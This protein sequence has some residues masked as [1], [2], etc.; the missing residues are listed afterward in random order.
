M[1]V[2]VAAVNLGYVSIPDFLRAT[3]SVPKRIGII[4]P[5][6]VIAAYKDGFVEGM[7][8]LGYDEG[9]NVIY[10]I[11]E[12]GGDAQKIAQAVQELTSANDIDLIF[13]LTDSAARSKEA[14]EKAG[15]QTPVVFVGVEDPVAAKLVASYQSSGNNVTGIVGGLA[16]VTAKKLEFL[17]ELAPQ[18]SRLG[19]FSLDFV[20]RQP[21]PPVY[22]SLLKEA[23]SLGFQIVRFDR[24]KK[25]TPIT[26]EETQEVA[27]SI[28][29]GTIDAIFHIP[30]HT[31]T[32]QEFIEPAAAIRLKVPNIGGIPIEVERGALFSYSPDFK[33]VG[34]QAAIMAD[35]I[36]KGTSPSDI[37]IEQ[38]RK[39]LL[40][41]NLATAKAIGITIPQHLIAIMDI[42]YDK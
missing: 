35:K 25:D 38:P 40:A 8:E 26:I 28:R 1:G 2:A 33:D 19:V 13:A 4:V 32:E 11:R 29:S 3:P 7:K 30:G 34:K 15:K 27:D 31:L 21:G 42:R 36:F 12:A 14:L 17:K 41:F 20:N 24:T 23:P 9:K 6:P 10:D 39:Y 5:A 16:A 18:T 22:A 37:P